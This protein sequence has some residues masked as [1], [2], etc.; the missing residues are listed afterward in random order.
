MLLIFIYIGYLT[1]VGSVGSLPSGNADYSMS[2]FVRR[3]F[4]GT[5]ANT[6]GNVVP[7]FVSI[8]TL[9]STSNSANLR[10]QDCHNIIVYHWDNDAFF[11]NYPDLDLCNAEWHHFFVSYEA[12]TRTVFLAVD[13]LF[14]GTRVLAADIDLQQTN[15]LIGKTVNDEY[16]DSIIDEV[17]IWDKNWKQLS[18]YGDETRGQAYAMLAKGMS[19][20]HIGYKPFYL[21]DVL[22]NTIFY[23]TFLKISFHFLLRNIKD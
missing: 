7:G 18:V 4:T 8:G 22:F 21:S 17:A 3:T 23:E 9:A 12:S 2:F 16:A 10:L 19:P 15:I 1:N 13:G 14:R 20:L 11:G 5:N 6:M